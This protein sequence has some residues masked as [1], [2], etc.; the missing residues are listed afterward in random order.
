MS[1]PYQVISQS[2]IRKNQKVLKNENIEL[3]VKPYPKKENKN[4]LKNQKI[5]V[6]CPSCKQRSWV[7]FY[8]GCFCQNCPCIFNKQKHQID[9]KVR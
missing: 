7:E 1:T 9:E 5:V 3:E 4:L 2:R 8:E 6:E